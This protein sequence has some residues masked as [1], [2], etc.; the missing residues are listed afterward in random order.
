MVAES[1]MSQASTGDESTTQCGLTSII[2]DGMASVEEI[3]VYKSQIK[4]CRDLLDCFVQNV[5]DKS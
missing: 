1:A 5:D 4:T 3:A 2:I